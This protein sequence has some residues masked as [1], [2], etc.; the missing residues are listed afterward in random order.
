MPIIKIYVDCYIPLVE[1]CLL[2][3]VELLYASC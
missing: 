1:Q 3:E 2:N